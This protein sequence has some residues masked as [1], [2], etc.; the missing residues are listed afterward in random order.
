MHDPEKTNQELLEEISLL[1][2][3]IKE[4]ELYKAERKQ[5][6][7]ALS[8]SRHLLSDLNE[9]SGAL[10]CDKDREGH[11]GL[12]NSKWEEVTG[13][14][15]QDVI[16]RT[17]EELFPGPVGRQ[18]RMNDLEVMKSESALEKEEVLKDEQGTR[19]FISNKFPLR[20]KLEIISFQGL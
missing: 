19:F 13:L 14:K 17:D 9:H 15:R 6:E 16:G 2:K 10:I 7:E 11:Y 8:K 20:E 1:N 4:L 18:F 3:K 12:V 5:M